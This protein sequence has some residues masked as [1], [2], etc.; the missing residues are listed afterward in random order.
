VVFEDFVWLWRSLDRQGASSTVLPSSL[1]PGRCG[2]LD[3][4]E[5]FPSTTNNVRL[6]P[7]GAAAA[8]CHRHSLEVEDEGL[9]KDL[10]VIYIFLKV[11]YTVHCF[12]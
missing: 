4:F 9:L 3:P 10:V 1:S 6:T 12:F 2:L 5:D 8:A 7:G 11:F